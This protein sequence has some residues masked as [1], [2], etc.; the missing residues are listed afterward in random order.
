MLNNLP[1]GLTVAQ[2]THVGL[3]RKR[4]E[5]S[6]WVMNSELS[7]RGGIDPVGLFV[8]ADGM[9]GHQNGDIASSTAARVVASYVVREFIVPLIINHAL[10]NNLPPI[11]EVLSQAIET[12]NA[13]V[14]Q[15]IPNAGTTLTA[16]LV[17]TN[18]IYLGHVGD[19]RAY[20]FFN[21]DFTQITKDHS[22][23]AQLD[24]HVGENTQLDTLNVNRNIL[25]KAVGQEDTL[26]VDTMLEDFPASSCLLLCTDGLWDKVPDRE[27][28]NILSIS[29]TPKAAVQQLIAEANQRGG[30]DNITA[31][32]VV[33]GKST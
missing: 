26:V 2:A 21:G 22:L 7:D 15:Q 24:E 12:A 4:N 32:L 30:D 33:H 31:V 6:Y 19:S 27:I 11:T 29:P 25:Y 10:A 3:K 16:A 17:L 8:I 13:V 18:R 14:S 23:R 20:L 5:D 28:R 1:P 9:G